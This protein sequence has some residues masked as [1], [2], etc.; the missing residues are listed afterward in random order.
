MNTTMKI[1]QY[2]LLLVLVVT[3]QQ[4]LAQRIVYSEPDREDNRRINFEIIGKIGSNFL[5]Y[6]NI[7][8]KN[9]ISLYNNEMVASKPRS[10]RLHSG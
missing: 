10:A 4:A 7:R 3:G 6:K 9:F 2:T 8:G 1:L 5:V